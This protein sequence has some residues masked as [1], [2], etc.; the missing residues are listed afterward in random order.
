MTTAAQ[1]AQLLRDEMGEILRLS[2]VKGSDY[3]GKEDTLRF[4]K[5]RARELD[6]T[7]QQVWAVLAGKHWSAIMS[8]AKEAGND[9]YNPSEP[10]AGRVRDLVVYLFLFLAMDAEEFGAGEDPEID[11][12]SDAVPEEVLRG[13]VPVVRGLL[14]GSRNSGDDRLSSALRAAEEWLEN[15]EELLQGDGGYRLEPGR[16]YLIRRQETGAF[17]VGNSGQTWTHDAAEARRVPGYEVRERLEILPDCHPVD[18][19]APLATELPR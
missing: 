18:P 2:E 10:V 3:S 19:L 4:F 6:M 17:W 14:H 7:P 5:E 8:A 9:G 1:F 12:I 13:G 16:E 15:A 11:A